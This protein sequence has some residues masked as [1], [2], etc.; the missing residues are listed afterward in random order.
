MVNSPRGCGMERHECKALVLIISSLC[1][2]CTDQPS[3]KTEVK[4]GEP[5]VVRSAECRWATGPIQIDGKL[6]EAAWKNA[7]LIKDFAV[8][9]QGRPAKT[10]TQARLLW[11]DRF[12]YFGAEMEDSDLY[13]DVTE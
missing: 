9:W 1:L 8:Y 11:D 5:A 10:Q 7:Q 2:G 12:L 4:K 13:A 6:D 3:A